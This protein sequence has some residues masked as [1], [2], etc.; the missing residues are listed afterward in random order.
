MINFACKDFDLEK[1]IKC[2]LSLTKSE[3]KILKLLMDVSES[4]SSEEVSRNVQIDLSTAQRSLKKLREKKLI[5]RTQTNLSP[6]GYVFLYKAK[7][8][9]EIKNKI[10]EVIRLWNQKLEFELNNW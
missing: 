7:N 5:E 8:K 2:S 9:T 10:S 3:Y 1:V 4:L 6:G